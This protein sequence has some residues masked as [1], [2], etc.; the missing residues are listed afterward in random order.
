MRIA[1]LGR[2][3]ITGVMMFCGLAAAGEP[4]QPSPSTSPSA[5]VARV[6]ASSQLI[7]TPLPYAIPPTVQPVPVPLPPGNGRVQ[8]LVIT[9]RNSFEHDWRG[10]THAIRRLLEDSG[11]FEVH[12]IEDFRGASARTLAAYDVVLLNYLGRW[13]Y[14]DPVE[15]RWG[16]AEEQ[17]LFEWVRAGHGLVVYHAS[18]VAGS[19][20][21][22]EYEELV[23]GT[24]RMS[25][26]PARRNPA[27]AFQVHI[28][29]HSHPITA[30]MREYVWTFDDDMYTN[31]RWFPGRRVNVLA[32]GYDDPAAYD[33]HHAG[34]KYPANRYS[35]AQ[36]A[37]MDS[38]A[39][40]NPLVWT[41]D[42]GSGRVFAFTLGHGPQSLGYDGVTSLLA[43]GT[44]WAATSK[45]T[46]PLLEKA[47]AYLPSEIAP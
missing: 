26:S 11:R 35:P 34:P 17:A 8:V 6:E 10:T 29:D 42:Y 21:W 45:V 47:R 20:D 9:G 3:F 38:M 43:R 41:A 7:A 24:M 23:G 12:V 1:V 31:L 18:I 37:R 25:P 32:T 4:S 15:E 14:T 39:K 2:L 44:E 40:E 33:E 5:P 16:T 46:L 36:L 22:P 28:V 19:P 30:G 13:H 27:D